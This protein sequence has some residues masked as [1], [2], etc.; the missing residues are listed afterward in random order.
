MISDL[1]ISDLGISEVATIL[2][3]L[4]LLQDELIES[5]IEAVKY[6]LPQFNDVAPMNVDSI[7]LLCEKI[8]CP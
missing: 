2:A 3:G 4:R 6:S 7:D 5:G 8:N 1:K